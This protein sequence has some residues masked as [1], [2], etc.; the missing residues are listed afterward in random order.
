MRASWSRVRTVGSNHKLPQQ[1]LGF[2]TLPQQL[3]H[4][5]HI[6]CTS[7]VPRTRRTFL[8]PANP[9]LQQRLQLLDQPGH[10]VKPAS[11]IGGVGLVSRSV[12]VRGERSNHLKCFIP[13]QHT[14]RQIRLQG[15]DG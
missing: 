15:P 7:L 10:P 12:E 11:S 3:H 6:T 4:R 1:P 8:Q 5:V 9:R 2:L 14:I 13:L